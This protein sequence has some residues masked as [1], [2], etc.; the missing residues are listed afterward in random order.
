MS[1][2]K[3]C[4]TLQAAE[5]RSLRSPLPA[6]PLPPCT[7]PVPA[8][9]PGAVPGLAT[10]NLS[11]L[12]KCSSIKQQTLLLAQDFR[13][14]RI[15]ILLED[16][17]D[18]IR[19]AARLGS[20]GLAGSVGGLRR[21]S[22]VGLVPKPREEP[23][24]PTSKTKG[25]IGSRGLPVAAMA[26]DALGVSRRSLAIRCIAC[27]SEILSCASE[28]PGLARIDRTQAERRSICVS[29]SSRSGAPNN[30]LWFREG[31]R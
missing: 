5:P 14:S 4:Q 10:R 13:R 3:I 11:I 15:S 20:A 30:P 18:P 24:G 2:Y 26:S 25:A 27:S 17:S 1:P 29:E 22:L 6:P 23:C 9:K 16:P 19:G 28:A 7:A 21:A 31:Y 8:S 12:L